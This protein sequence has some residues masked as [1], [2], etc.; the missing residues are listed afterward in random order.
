MEEAATIT[1]HGLPSS[2]I[3]GSNVIDITVSGGAAPQT[4]DVLILFENDI[5]TDPGI[6]YLYPCGG[7]VLLY[8]DA[9]Y[10]CSVEQEAPQNGPG[11][12][13]MQTATYTTWAQRNSLHNGRISYRKRNNI[14]LYYS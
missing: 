11:V 12:S 5:A 3:Q 13:S 4:G 2:Y 8:Q 10:G 9:G 6:G 14:Y 1:E 7:S